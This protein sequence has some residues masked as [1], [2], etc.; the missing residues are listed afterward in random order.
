MFVRRFALDFPATGLTGGPIQVR[1][2]YRDR[3]GETLVSV[4]RPTGFV[5]AAQHAPGPATLRACRPRAMTGE[6]L[7]V[8]G[9]IPDIFALRL[10][11]DGSISAIVVAAS[12]GGAQVLLPPTLAPGPHR[13]AIAGSSASLP[14]NVVA[15]VGS[16]DQNRLW[17]GE[18]TDMQL[19]V[20]GSP[21]PIELRIENRT[22]QI[23]ELEGGVDQTVRT[24]GGA[25]N[26][27]RRN[28]RGIMR[29]NFTIDYT[30]DLGPCPCGVTR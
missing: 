1:I 6:Q 23:I 24:S 18:R 17:R 3:F 8:C 13:I 2:G 12:P 19:R 7:C 28:V 29:G 10:S 26:A 9:S 16:L 14:F 4:D 21:D 22:P 27:L 30:L 5:P 25:D 15:V 11:I 20:L